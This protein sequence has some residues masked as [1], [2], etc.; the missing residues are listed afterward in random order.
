[1]TLIGLDIGGTNLRAVSV[2]PAGNVTAKASRDAGGQIARVDL[3]AAIEDIVREVSVSAAPQFIG[4]ALGG[5]IELDGTMHMGSRICRISLA[6]RS[7][8]PFQTGSAFLA[9]LIMTPGRRCAA[10]PGLVQLADFA[11]C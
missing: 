7:S 1:M 11:T 4:V 5:K 6:C 10:R 3:L 2:T 9:A 8:R